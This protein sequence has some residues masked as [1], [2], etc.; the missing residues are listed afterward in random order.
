[1][2][3]TG[4]SNIRDVTAYPRVPVTP[5]SNPRKLRFLTGASRGKDQPQKAHI[6]RQYDSRT[7]RQEQI[8][9]KHTKCQFFYF[10]TFVL[11]CG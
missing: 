1:M 2:L 9:T 4:I 11:S 8:T 3:A 6:A 7:A 5:N 10:V